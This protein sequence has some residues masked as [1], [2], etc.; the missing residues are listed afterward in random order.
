MCNGKDHNLEEIFRSGSD[1]SD[2]YYVVM[3][4]SDCGA[5]V[6]DTEI[7][8]RVYPGDVMKM[9]FPLSAKRNQQ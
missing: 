3:W 7:D 1:T 5:V 4:C 9:R 2:V 8:G 6:I